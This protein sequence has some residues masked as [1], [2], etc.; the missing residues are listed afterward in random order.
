MTMN[1]SFADWYRPAAIVPAEGLLQRRW[2]AVEQIASESTVERVIGL[3]RLFALPASEIA[4]PAGL[5]EAFKA[6]DETFPMK[7]DLHELQILAGAV[8]REI[9]E[10]NTICAIPAA[11]GLA[12]V[13]FATRREPVPEV[14]HIDAAEKFLIV[15]AQ[16]IRTRKSVG[17]FHVSQIS[18]EE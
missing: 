10:T 3:L 9:I 2:A 13:A 14:E 6:H 5:K 18:P 17:D 8:L 12:C 7:G 1:P 11:L 15:Q 4:V 16:A